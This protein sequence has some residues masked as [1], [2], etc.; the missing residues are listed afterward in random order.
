V[1]E[2]YLGFEACVALT[3][4]ASSPYI[5]PAGSDGDFAL[6]FPA[7]WQVLPE[8]PKRPR[9]GD[10]FRIF[11]PDGSLVARDGDVLEVTG[12]INAFEGSRCGFGWPLRVREAHRVA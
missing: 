1:G 3:P 6:L 7:G 4:N 9:Y 8:H 2:I 5:P 12:E 11:A 10:H